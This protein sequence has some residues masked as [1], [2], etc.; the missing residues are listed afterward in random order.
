MIVTNTG[1]A[2]VVVVVG[3][4]A[5]S[6]IAQVCCLQVN[7]S[8]ENIGPHLIK[9]K[10]KVLAPSLPLC[11]LHILFPSTETTDLVLEKRRKN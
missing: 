4:K 9:K 10:E 8:R 3:A 1:Y 6:H 2:V 11:V 7:T 5:V